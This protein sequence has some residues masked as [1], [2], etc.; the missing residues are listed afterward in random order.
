MA[1][2]LDIDPMQKF[3]A[4]FVGPNGSGKSIAI[5]SWMKLGSVYFFDYDGRMNSVANWYKKRGLKPGQLLFDTYGPENLKDA[6]DKLKQFTQSCPHAAIVLDSFTAMTITAVTFSMY[7]RM[8]KSGVNMPKETKGDLLVPDWD[9]W[10]GEAMYVTMALD[11]CKQ[12]AAAGTAVFWTGH[13]VQRMNIKEEGNRQ[14]ISYQTKYA[15]FGHKSDSLI[16]L[17]FNEIYAFYPETDLQTNKVHRICQTQPYGEIAA[18]T[19]FDL[20]V[21]LDWTDGDFRQIFL[22]NLG[23]EEQQNEVKS[24]TI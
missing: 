5:A 15:A 14:K 13:P 21:R 2:I 12:I 1:D 22:D 18:K 7:R 9:E 20:P 3:M 23:K 24:I 19:A 17:Y 8:A 10:N 4:F 6:L 11:M 16:P